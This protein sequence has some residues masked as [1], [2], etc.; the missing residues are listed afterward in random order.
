LG[1]DYLLV[2]QDNGSGKK[3]DAIR[4]ALAAY[5]LSPSGIEP[6]WQV[7]DQESRQSDTNKTGCIHGESIP[8]VLRG[9]FA[10]TPDLRV[11]DLATGKVL[12][13]SSGPPPLNGG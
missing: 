9:K 13:Q 3:D 5:K 2:N 6:L 1:R 10:F 4:P 7:T 8:V 11:V 12:D